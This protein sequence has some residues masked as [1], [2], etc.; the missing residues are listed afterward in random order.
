MIGVP[1]RRLKRL[2]VSPVAIGMIFDN[3]GLLVSLLVIVVFR[4]HQRVGAEHLV[5]NHTVRRRF[6]GYFDRY[7]DRYLHDPILR[8]TP[9]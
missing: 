8:V 3:D 9:G 6:G 1:V 5:G 7:L 4:H 2:E